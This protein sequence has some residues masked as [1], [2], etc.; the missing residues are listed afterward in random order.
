MSSPTIDVYRQF[1]EGD[2]CHTSETAEE[3]MLEPKRAGRRKCRAGESRVVRGSGVFVAA[4]LATLGAACN[5]TF[6][7]GASAPRGPLPVDERNPIVIFNDSQYDNWQGEYALLLANSGGPTLA[8]IVVNTSPNATNIDDNLADRQALVAAA[9]NSH[10][11]NVP[12]PIRSVGAALVRPANGDIDATLPNR[13]EG[14]L[15]IVSESARLSLPYRPLV[16]VTGG[17]LTDVADAYLVD[18]AVTE[19][20]VVVSHMGSLTATGAVMG[21]PNGEMDPWAD[22]IVTARFR[23]VQV[24]AYYDQTT[25]VPTSRLSDLP[26]NAFGT[27]IASRQSEI[28]DLPQAADQGVVAAVWIPGYVMAVTRASAAGPVAA[29]ATTGPVISDDPNGNL[30]LVRQ[31]SGEVATA[32]FWEILLNPKTYGP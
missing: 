12:D 7:A 5:E 15:F 19:R 11:R 1:L 3:S 21:P 20:V 9:R 25:D 6:D 8:G 26:T 28:W 18:H 22:S 4:L 13:S 30:W 16:L 31:V 2:P 27:W 14:A 32:R 17:R 23:F 29:G 24:S 10:M